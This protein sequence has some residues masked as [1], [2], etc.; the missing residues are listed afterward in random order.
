MSGPPLR[1]SLLVLAAAA[2]FLASLLLIRGGFLSAPG[3]EPVPGALWPHP[4]PLS[5][6]VLADHTGQAFDLERLRG[7]WSFLFFGY[8]HCPDICPGTLTTLSAVRSELE[9]SERGQAPAQFVFV[10]VDP[11]RDT[12]ERLSSYVRHFHPDFLGVTG[13]PH[14]LEGLTRPLG[15][16]HYRGPADASGG[17]LVDHSA[18]VLL[19]DPQARLA[20]VF[21]APHQPRD[22]AERFRRVR[23]LTEG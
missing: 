14:A 5:P 17:Y 20:A 23:A 22:L 12:P 9:G 8:T 3:A 16:V 19:V 13:A 6:F 21:S 4:K 11:E 10:S 18:A 7:R 1:Y 15:I 2:G